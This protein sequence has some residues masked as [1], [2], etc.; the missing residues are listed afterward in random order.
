MEYVYTPQKIQIGA[1]GLAALYQEIHTLLATRKGSVPF[2][3]DFG[4]SW[5]FID[6]PIN[7]AKSAM[8]SELVT[9]LE[10]YVPRIKVMGIEF[11]TNM[12][13][14]GRLYP[15]ILFAVREEYAEEFRNEFS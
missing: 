13:L 10:K 12:N 1:S 3:R 9:Q 5:D 4:I 7:F 11:E 6:S 14:D 8:V 15:K 2:D